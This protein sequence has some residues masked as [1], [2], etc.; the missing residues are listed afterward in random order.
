MVYLQVRDLS[1]PLL[2]RVPSICRLHVTHLN[3]ENSKWT[4]TRVCIGSFFSYINDM[5]TRTCVCMCVCV[6]VCWG[7]WWIGGTESVH[8]LS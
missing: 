5:C 4:Y 3:T 7:G 2:L 6:C 8:V 1:H